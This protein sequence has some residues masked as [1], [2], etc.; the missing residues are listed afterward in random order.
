LEETWFIKQSHPKTIL[1]IHSKGA[2]NY[3]NALLTIMQNIYIFAYAEYSLQFKIKITKDIFL[4]GKAYTF[5]VT[6]T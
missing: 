6:L 3:I 1:F 4:N 5:F 2:F